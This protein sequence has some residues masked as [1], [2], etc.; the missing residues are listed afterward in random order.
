MSCSL[1]FEINNDISPII[2]VYLKTLK[3]RKRLKHELNSKIQRSLIKQFNRTESDASKYF[4]NEY[5]LPNYPGWI[6]LGKRMVLHPNINQA[7]RKLLVITEKN[8]GYCCSCMKKC[9]W[10][11]CPERGERMK[12]IRFPRNIL[13]LNS[14][15]Y[16]DL[17]VLFSEIK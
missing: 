6:W 11:K 7:F 5:W 17:R 9:R 8:K 1:L 16:Y 4:G 15:G 10:R 3:N 13:N 14:M 2:E 12:V